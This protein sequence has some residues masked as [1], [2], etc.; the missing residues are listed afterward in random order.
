MELV[1]PHA[2]THLAFEFATEM[3]KGGTLFLFSKLGIRNRDV[4]R[5]A[6]PPLAPPFVAEAYI[7][8]VLCGTH[9][10]SKRHSVVSW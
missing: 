9:P 7:A 10:G 4:V 5:R 6:L 2:A 8:F 3:R 1:R